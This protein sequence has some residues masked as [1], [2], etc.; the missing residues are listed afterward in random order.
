MNKAQRK[1]LEGVVASLKQA[2][3]TIKKAAARERTA[4]AAL[5]ENEQE[6]VWGEVLSDNATALE[7]AVESLDEAITEFDG[8][9]ISP[10]RD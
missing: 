6:G 2:M 5:P 7:A 9:T 3:A 4:Y 8:L 10:D 1:E